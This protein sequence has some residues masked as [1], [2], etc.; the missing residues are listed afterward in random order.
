M[1]GFSD[2]IHPLRDGSSPTSKTR[3]SSVETAQPSDLEGFLRK[4]DQAYRKRH[5][6]APR[7]IRAWR[8]EHAAPAR[9]LLR[10]V[11]GQLATRIPPTSRREDFHRSLLSGYDALDA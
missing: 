4:E 6:R 5:S 7:D 9:L 1:R 10:L 2:T 3:T 11:H 8:V